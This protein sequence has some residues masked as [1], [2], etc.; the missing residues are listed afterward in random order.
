M[1]NI[2]KYMEW[3]LGQEHTCTC[4]HAHVHMHKQITQ[5]SKKIINE[6]KVLY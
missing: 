6:I 1:E 4:T 5:K 3:T 2:W